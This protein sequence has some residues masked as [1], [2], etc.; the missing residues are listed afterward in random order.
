MRL[1]VLI[2]IGRF[3]CSSSGLNHGAGLGGQPTDAAR[4]QVSQQRRQLDI[5]SGANHP[6]TEPEEGAGLDDPARRD[7]P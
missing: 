6:D 2:V 7:R 5:P 4:G 1:S 3:S